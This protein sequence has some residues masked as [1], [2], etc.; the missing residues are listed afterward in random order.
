MRTR[1]LKRCTICKS[2]NYVGDRN[3]SKQPEKLETKKFCPKCN[4]QTL[5]KEKSKFK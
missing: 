4:A 1:H 3:H 5:H 2:E